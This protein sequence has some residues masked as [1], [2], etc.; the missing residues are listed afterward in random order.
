MM[1]TEDRQL[2]L[3]PSSQITIPSLPTVCISPKSV[4]PPSEHA[5]YTSGPHPDPNFVETCLDAVHIAKD[6]EQAGKLQSVPIPAKRR[7]STIAQL[8]IWMMQSEASNKDEDKI[9]PQSIGKELLTAA[10]VDK[11]SFSPDQKKEFDKGVNKI[12]LAAD[13]TRKEA[14]K[15]RANSQDRHR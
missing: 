3:E 2:Q 7:A 11:D 8:S 14:Q 13:L 5:Q 10:G 15:K 12:F 1:S 4:P 6:M 9:T